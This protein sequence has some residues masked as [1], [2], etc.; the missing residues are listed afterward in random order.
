MST[1]DIHHNITLYRHR[2]ASIGGIK[3]FNDREICERVVGDD[4]GKRAIQ[5]HGVGIEGDI[6]FTRLRGGRRVT[7]QAQEA[8][9]DDSVST[10][11]AGGLGEV[12]E[13]L[14]RVSDME[15]L[16]GPEYDR[17]ALARRRKR[18]LR[19]QHTAVTTDDLRAPSNGRSRLHLSD[20]L[21]FFWVS[22]QQDAGSSQV[23]ET[24]DDGVVC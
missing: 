16:S 22:A 1:L 12:C 8:I 20:E 3:H 23:G 9:R 19:R 6:K 24:L 17:S 10:H 2:H 11:V 21:T 13:H 5:M 18:K 7:K 4:G 14:H 15:Q